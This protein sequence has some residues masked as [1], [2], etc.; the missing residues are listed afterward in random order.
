MSIARKCYALK[1]I[2][3]FEK[4]IHEICNMDTVVQ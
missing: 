4:L 3:Y 2:I 1:N